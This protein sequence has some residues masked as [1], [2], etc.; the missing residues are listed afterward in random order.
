M[1]FSANTQFSFDVCAKSVKTK[2]HFYTDVPVYTKYIVPGLQGAAVPFNST[3]SIMREVD[4]F[5]PRPGRKD[6][7]FFAMPL[8]PPS[9][10]PATCDVLPINASQG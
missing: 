5:F 7:Y 8:F 10:L 9:H 6:S 2:K 3:D 4:D 1:Y